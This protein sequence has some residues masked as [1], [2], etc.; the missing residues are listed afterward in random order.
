VSSEKNNASKRAA[1][2][3]LEPVKLRR[4]QA[5]VFSETLRRYLDALKIEQTQ[6]AEETGISRQEIS[7]WTG[8]KKRPPGWLD[9]GRMAAVIFVRMLRMEK[10]GGNIPAGLRF[11]NALLTQ[12][13]INAAGFKMNDEY[14]DQPLWRRLEDVDKKGRILRVGWFPWGDF[15]RVNNEKHPASAPGNF[16]GLSEKLCRR[17]CGLLGV[18][19]EP[20]PIEVHE[21]KTRL[22]D[23][24]V[25][26]LAPLIQLPAR[27]F[28]F[29]CSQRIPGLW[30]GLSMLVQKKLWDQSFLSLQRVPLEK[31]QVWL[32]KEGVADVLL[33][34]NSVGEVIEVPSFDEALEGVKQKHVDPSTERFRAF[35]AD[36]VSCH[37]AEKSSKPELVPIPQDHFTGPDAFL[38]QH[39]LPVAFGVHPN[40]TRFLSVVNS[41]LE[42]MADDG[43]E[44]LTPSPVSLGFIEKSTAASKR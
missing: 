13:F 23:G 26:L 41:C 31:F 40:E 2:A 17:L 14:D 29:A 34:R 33:P 15:A 32:V 18:A 22:W 38:D 7:M 12:E 1:S 6:L 3:P 16:G 27:K 30:V 11:D 8:G 42:I 5:R 43:P 28:A 39:T 37:H 36:S 19:M 24:D 10:D 25:D 21:M 9:A 44:L 4:E 35:M 20:V